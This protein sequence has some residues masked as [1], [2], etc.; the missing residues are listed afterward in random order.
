MV[1]TV[2]P[3]EAVPLPEFALFDALNRASST[4]RKGPG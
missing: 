4:S 2:R 1:R 3:A